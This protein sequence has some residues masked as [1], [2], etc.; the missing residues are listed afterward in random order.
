MS[1]P[2]EPVRPHPDAVSPDVARERLAAR[3]LDA[4]APQPRDPGPLLTSTIRLKVTDVMVYERN[5]RRASHERIVELKESIRV[6]GIEQ[7]IS[8]TRRPA[9]PRYVVA[10]GGNS[11]LTAA[12]ALYDETH[13]ERF[14]HYDFLYVPYPGE[15][16]LLAAHLR[17]N[18]QR[19]DLCFWDKAN[20]YL[21]LKADLE[22]E[23]GASLSLREFSR[24]LEEEGTPVSH[25]LLSLFQF[26][27]DRLAA[28]GPATEW[29]SRRSL[30]DVIQP[31]IGQ[32]TRLARKLCFDDAWL[33]H[34][35]ID[36]EL[37]Q[38]AAS[39]D[40]ASLAGQARERGL[41]A[42]Q[43]VV[44]I[45]QRCADSLDVS[46]VGLERMCHLLDRQSDAAINTVREAGGLSASSAGDTPGARLHEVGEHSPAW[47][48]ITVDIP[49][50]VGAQA[51][52]ESD[53]DAVGSR[54]P[55]AGAHAPAGTEDPA[56]PVS[57]RAP[58]GGDGA[59]TVVP[60]PTEGRTGEVFREALLGFVRACGLDGC[61]HDAPGL[62]YGFMVEPPEPVGSRP[63]LD[64]QAQLD[65][66]ALNRYLG[67]WW[68]V[69]LSRQNTASG[70]ELVPR[71]SRYGR[72]AH[73]EE[74]WTR[75]CD[76]TIGEPL[77]AD[78]MNVMFDAMLN[79][80]R[81]IGEWWAQ[82]LD[83]ARAFRRAHPE[84]FTPPHWMELDA[85]ER[86]RRGDGT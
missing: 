40:T 34:T 73:D 70:L 15:T 25:V 18:E 45:R 76:A 8:V 7:I 12:K 50:P 1:A 78:R 38:I 17:E 3:R 21:A 48:P 26:A 86:L 32:L 31:A 54:V 41:D 46:R 82:L 20:G 37:R 58:A 29:L 85:D 10:K 35:V 66:P 57:G 42:A 62:P 55:D 14:L 69:S 4:K 74:Y 27:I 30:V 19:A 23:R 84:R 61:V 83:V 59:V 81:A 9:E 71:T 13:D 75:V 68:L 77:L 6:N 52:G 2:S 36:P 64:R 43:L 65:E 28:L 24:L 11:R 33:Q 44:S 5:P 53:R 47:T 79:P 63:A 16:K 72:M 67:W 22:C 51:M 49:E 80:G 60:A 56:R 39:I